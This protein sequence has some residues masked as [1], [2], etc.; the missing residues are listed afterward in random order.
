MTVSTDLIKVSYSGD[1]STTVFAYTFKVF[2][3]D[4]LVVI[5]RDANGVETTKTITTDYTVSGVGNANGG[6]VTMLTAPAS[7][8]TLLILREQPITQELDLVPNDPFPADSIEE[9]LDKLVFMMQQ[10][11]EELDRCI[12]LSKTN[13]MTSTEFTVSAADRANEVFS[14]D[15]SGELSI[16]ALGV[17]GAVTLPLSVSNGGTAATDAA[18]ART[19]LGTTDEALALAIALG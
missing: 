11:A 13:T 16:Q 2:D 1:D 7:T 12:K 4:D 14:F 17:V 19:N 5:I 10:Q 6:N 18:T 8:E 3:E 9:A 15:A